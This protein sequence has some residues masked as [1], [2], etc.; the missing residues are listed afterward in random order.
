[1]GAVLAGPRDYSWTIAKA[2]GRSTSV[3]TVSQ[4]LALATSHLHQCTPD[5][6]HNNPTAFIK[7][8]HCNK[9]DDSTAVSGEDG[10]DK[11]DMASHAATTATAI[12]RSTAVELHA[13]CTVIE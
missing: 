11:C 2:Y 13:G 10:E 7:P 8:Y 4:V 5:D 1:V 3:G 12:F 6:T 9:P